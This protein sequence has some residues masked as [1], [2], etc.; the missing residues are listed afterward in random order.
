MRAINDYERAHHIPQGWVNFSISQTSPDGAWH[1]LE[2][3]EIKMDAEFFKGFNRDLRR[4]DLWRQFCSRRFGDAY[5]AIAQNVETP[6]L[7]DID[8]EWLF[9]EMMRVSR[10]P[11]P[12]M[13]PALKR[14]KASRKYVL[15]ALSNAY[16]FPDDH[17]YSK[18]TADD[19]KHFFDV[20][21]SSARVGL[22]KP[23]P[24]IYH[25][26]VREMDRFARE[27][28]G[29]VDGTLGWN[30]G[31]TAGD[32]VF[33]DDIGA[34]LKTAKEMGMQTIKVEID[35]GLRAVRALERLTRLE[36]VDERE[37]SKL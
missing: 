7:P 2:R 3:G 18:P 33:L 13:Y 11:D 19:P 26:A 22:R 6:P 12:W 37:K 30:E 36:L 1:R 34:N 8:G 9:W 16:V 10:T 15:G 23:D 27:H 14:L 29:D 20:F 21:I 24:Q 17:E 25:L 28:A 31:V 4:A 32:I 5:K 35:E